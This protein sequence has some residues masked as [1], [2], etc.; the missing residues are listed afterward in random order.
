MGSTPVLA[1]NSDRN[2][3]EIGAGDGKK[4]EEGG[5][6]IAWCLYVSELGGGGESGVT[7]FA[8]NVV[9]LH[10]YSSTSIPRNCPS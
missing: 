6:V 2:D 3:A 1:R 5:G 4:G 7:D 8:L 9:S 10:I